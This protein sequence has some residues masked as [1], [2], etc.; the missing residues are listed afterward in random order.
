[1]KHADYRSETQDSDSENPPY[2]GTKEDHFRILKVVTRKYEFYKKA[3]EH[4]SFAFLAMMVISVITRYSKIV[5]LPKMIFM[6]ALVILSLLGLWTI[7]NK[8]IWKQ[9]KISLEKYTSLK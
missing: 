2:F 1:M 4:F 3:E 9:R 8:R 7:V 6:W 5:T